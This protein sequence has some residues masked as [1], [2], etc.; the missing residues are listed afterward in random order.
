MRYEVQNTLPVVYELFDDKQDALNK[1][2]EKHGLQ[3]YTR[4]TVPS[5]IAEAYFQVAKFRLDITDII[6]QKIPVSHE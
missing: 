3:L 5:D 2:L 1:E 6:I 4:E